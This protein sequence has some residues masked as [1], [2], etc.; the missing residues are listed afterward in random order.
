LREI[1]LSESKIDAGIQLHESDVFLISGLIFYCF[2][3]CI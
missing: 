1:F 3:S 2:S